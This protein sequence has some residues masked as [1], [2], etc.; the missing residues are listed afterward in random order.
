MQEGAKLEAAVLDTKAKPL[1]F[2]QG[3][4]EIQIKAKVV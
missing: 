4:R 3:E 1:P 2:I